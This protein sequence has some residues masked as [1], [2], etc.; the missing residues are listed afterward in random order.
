MIPF[1]RLYAIVD[2]SC[3]PD[4]QELVK[5]TQELVEGGCTLLQYRNK[6]ENARVMLKQ[7][8]AL[9][10]VLLSTGIQNSHVSQNRDIR[11]IR[12]PAVRVIM[13]DRADLCLAAEFDGVHV[14]QEDLS[15][16]S[17]RRIIGPDRWLGISTHNPLQLQ[18]A[19]L[20]PADYVAI[21]PVFATSSKANPDPVIGLEGVRIARSLTRKPLVAIGGITRAT[22]ASVVE[23]GA[24]CVAVISDLVR[25]PRKSAEEFLRILR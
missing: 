21:G 8:R 24:D 10:Q 19:Q 9:R 13:N 1:P 20:M 22:A 5:H 12:V 4:T 11:D 3:F 14:G 23:A 17:V 15:P 16:E 2:A 6:S 7:A 25:E 18:A